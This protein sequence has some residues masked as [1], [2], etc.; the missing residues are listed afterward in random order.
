[1]NND[2]NEIKAMLNLMFLAGVT[3]LEAVKQMSG[4]DH[5]AVLESVE[6]LLVKCKGKKEEVPELTNKEKRMVKFRTYMKNIDEEGIPWD[7]I[8]PELMRRAVI[9]MYFIDKAQYQIN[10]VDKETLAKIVDDVLDY[11]A[12][13]E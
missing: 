12:E 4:Y 3:P 5:D 7:E 2:K 9:G 10:N 6:E 11:V 8:T 13:G 1:M